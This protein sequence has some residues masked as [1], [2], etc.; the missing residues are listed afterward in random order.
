MSLEGKNKKIY[1]EIM[2]IIACTLVLFNHL[3]GYMLFNKSS[4]LKQMG[5]MTLTMLT[6]INVPIFFM[7]SGALLF[8]RSDD[9]ISVQKKRTLRII[10]LL[11][12]F[13]AILFIIQKY[14]FL[15]KGKSP[16]LKI[17]DFFL[18][19]LNKSIPG[20]GTYWYLYA[21]LGVL[22]LLPFMQRIAKEITKTEIIALI[23][24]HFVTASLFP[25][26]NIFLAYRKIDI[27]IYICGDFS[28]PFAFEKPFFYT[29]VGY[30]LEHNINYTKIKTKHLVTLILLGIIGI[31]L[32]NV[33]TLMDAKINGSYSQNYVQLFDYMTTIVVFIVIKYLVIVKNKTYRPRVEKVVCF[34]GSMTLGIYMIDPCLKQLFFE[35]YNKRME[36][37]LPTMMVTIG[38]IIFSMIS[39]TIITI[40]LKKIPFIKKI[41]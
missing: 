26:I 25:M 32:S 35:D 36:P 33:C 28:V 34:M 4:G 14:E 23:I 10:Y 24:L 39:G 30:Y 11:V 3:P 31:A 7:I 27:S 8:G 15:V 9:F 29:L 13:N 5:Y 38:W 2:R 40:V 20:A 1:F 22:F 19:L 16:D 6:R 18:S 21:Y 41:I 17:K 37:L 12:L